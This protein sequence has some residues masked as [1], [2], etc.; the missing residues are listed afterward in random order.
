[1]ASYSAKLV[2]ARKA[3]D[4]D[5]VSELDVTCESYRVRQYDTVA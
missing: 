1:M 2:Y 5:V 4:N 3:T